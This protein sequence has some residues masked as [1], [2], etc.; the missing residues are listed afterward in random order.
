M[1]E[2]YQLGQDEIDEIVGLLSEI[3]RSRH[4]VVIIRPYKKR[5]SDGLIMIAFAL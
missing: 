3:I 4:L 2:N 5:V 1:S